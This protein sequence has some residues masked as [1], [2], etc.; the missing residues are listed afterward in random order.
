M[1]TARRNK[2]YGRDSVA[3][4]RRWASQLYSDTQARLERT[5]RIEENYVFLTSIPRWREIFATCASGRNADHE[6]CDALEPYIERELHE[7]TFNNRIGMG[8]QAAIN[9]VMEDVF[10]VTQ[11]YTRP[12]RIIKLDL[13]GFFP[14]ANLDY[15]ERLFLR[16]IDKYQDNIIANA[17]TSGECPP[18]YAAEY[19][20]YLR[21]LAM[22]VIH[23]CPTHHCELRT[24]R[25]FWHENIA[26]EKSLFGKPDGIG[27][28]IGRLP[29]QKG[30]GLYVNDEVR[31][32]ND[33]CGIRTTC[34]MDDFVM[35]VPENRHRYVLSLIPALRRRLATKGV[36][37]NEK[38]FY[39]QP[40]Q[41]GLEFLGSHVR[42]NRLHLNDCTCRRGM[43]RLRWFN[44]LPARGRLSHLE[45]F[46]S[47]INSY[48]GLLK[49]RTDHNRLMTMLRSVDAG[50]WRYCR[51]NPRRQCIVANENYS[52]RNLIN[53]KHHLLTNKKI[54]H[55]DT[56]GK[57][58]AA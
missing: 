6:L 25:A 39:D 46:L 37:L 18:A 42:N 17:V 41:R 29:S 48:F 35:V 58:I 20:A 15:M 14:N 2:R 43:E 5:F 52:H 22:V 34:F 28:P 44:S 30:M 27:A 19:P 8:S 1:D 9:R 13:K 10:E 47:S 7:R 49:N 11:G 26:P 3:F 21:W 57:A 31:W 32:L 55:Y 16:I 4:E 12:A 56:T 23:C 38:K 53:S 45:G 51:Y 36:R 24:P 33:D 50:W 54:K 40:S